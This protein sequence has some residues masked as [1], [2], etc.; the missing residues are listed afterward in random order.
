VF[1]ADDVL[2]EG[3]PGVDSDKLIAE[4]GALIFDLQSR[5]NLADTHWGIA[6]T[7]PAYDRARTGSLGG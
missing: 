4:L 6:D 7:G 3:M 5:G 1:S 2:D